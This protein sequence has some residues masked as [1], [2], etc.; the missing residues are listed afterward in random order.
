MEGY[1]ADLQIAALKFFF[2]RILQNEHGLKQ[3]VATG[4]TI[5]LNDFDEVPK[6][7]VLIRICRKGASADQAESLA[8]GWASC[9]VHANDQ[10]IR[11]TAC[12]A[13]RFSQRA[14]CRTGPHGNIFMA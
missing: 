6:R 4:C 10:V 5:R 14:V 9:Q 11:K 3:A 12:D 8:K 7:A 1:A 2:R 13:L